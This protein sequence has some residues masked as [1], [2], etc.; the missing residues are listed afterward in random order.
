MRVRNDTADDVRLLTQDGSVQLAD[1]GG[2]DYSAALDYG[3]V[4][5]ELQVIAGGAT[6]EGTFTV[7]RTIASD[8][9]GLT[10][11]VKEDGGIGRI[12]SVRAHRMVD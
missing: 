11:V 6:V 1:S 5:P 4:S 3:S 12:W 8:A 7:G 2:E 10:V 9:G